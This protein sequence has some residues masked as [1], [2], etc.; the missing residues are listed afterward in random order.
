MGGIFK[1]LFGQEK[2]A[3]RSFQNR[4]PRVSIPVVDQTVFVST[5]GKTYP[6]R[7]I[8]ETGLAIATLGEEFPATL[9]G[10]IQVAGQSAAAELLVVRRMPDVAGVKIL[11]G[12][13]A[14]R[15]LFRRVFVDE[16]HAL[17]M[18]EVDSSRQKAV[19]LG[20]PR[21]F[22]APGNYE[23]FYVEHENR[24]IRFE[25]EWNGN[26]LSFVDGALRF[27]T[28]DRRDR[29]KVEHAASSLVQWAETVQPEHRQKAL[30]ILENIPGLDGQPRQQIQ[31]KLAP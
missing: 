16:I 27:G 7:N 8:S 29:E 1:K 9:K 30:R 22:Y 12:A 5:N 6:L 28:I 10:E 31:L 25:M 13:A 20:Q 23:L 24:V 19:E 15:G 18:T 11:E 17:E 2:P 4:S 3:P 14:V 26:L 21:W